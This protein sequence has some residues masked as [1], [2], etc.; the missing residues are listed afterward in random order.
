MVEMNDEMLLDKFLGCIFGG[1][2]ANSL[3][4][5][6]GGMPVR[7]IQARFPEIRDF[8]DPSENTYLPAIGNRG[9]WT[10]EIA[11]LLATMRALTKTRGVVQMGAIGEE[12]RTTY[13][14][15][16]RG[17]GRSDR[18]ACQRLLA[19]LDWQDSGEPWQP[20][21]KRGAGNGSMVS[22]VPLG[23]LQAVMNRNGVRKGALAFMSE[24]INY[25]FMT[26]RGP[27]AIIASVVH[28]S[29]I[30][31]FTGFSK[32]TLEAFRC[33]PEV[34]GG[35]LYSAVTTAEI[36][37]VEA[38]KRLRNAGLPF[39]CE[40]NIYYQILR[41]VSLYSIGNL[42][43]ATPKEIGFWFGNGGPYAFHS[44]G[45]AY[46]ML[47]RWVARL[48]DFN[49]DPFEPILWALYSGADQNTTTVVGELMGALCG[50]RAFPYHLVSGV[51]KS[52]EIRELTERFF[53]TCRTA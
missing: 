46:A 18:S 2:I 8:I 22:I 3:A 11:L 37:W 9:E 42:K 33:T 39:S 13:E 44:F 51:E 27:P 30:V 7:E 45:F 6:L 52:E 49:P 28:A 50:I 48:R 34:F 14:R 38:E 31:G 10:G 1:A 16:N 35:V 21:L 29:L 40:D 19:G 4:A 41:I 15:E 43:T 25:G 5:A 53:D 12:F 36:A 24:G 26:H 17:F 32:E 23:L 20:E 47:A